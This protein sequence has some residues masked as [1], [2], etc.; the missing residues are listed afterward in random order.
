MDEAAD[1]E[2]EQR[3][4]EATNAHVERLPQPLGVHNGLTSYAPFGSQERC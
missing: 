1:T 4:D 2:P 3:S